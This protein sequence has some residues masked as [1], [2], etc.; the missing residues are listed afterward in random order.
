MQSAARIPV[1]AAMGCA[2]STTHI[3]SSRFAPNEKMNPSETTMPV[4]FQGRSHTLVTEV[5]AAP[6]APPR[7]PSSSV[8]GPW[9]AWSIVVTVEECADGI[10]NEMQMANPEMATTS[11]NEAAATTRTGIF[12]LTPNPFF[13]SS[14]M[15][16]TTTAGDTAASMKPSERPSIKFIL[17]SII[18]TQAT[19]RASDT[20]GIAVSRSAT[21]PAFLTSSRSISRPPRRKMIVRPT[22]ITS[23]AHSSGS[24]RTVLNSTSP[25]GTMF[26]SRMPAS[27]FP[28][29]PGSPIFFINS[30]P[31]L[32]HSHVRVSAKPG[33][34]AHMNSA[35]KI[36]SS[37]V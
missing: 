8:T 1:E 20:P 28:V 37:M 21:V 32:L 3:C 33:P 24:P 31:A 14:N 35:L 25:F 29:S 36:N 27:R 18:E 9:V 11:S 7:I 2:C 30:P 5:T 34:H 6:R 26:L 16:P 15:A 17:N 4:R 22:V 23:L 19:V 12:C 10:A 13:L